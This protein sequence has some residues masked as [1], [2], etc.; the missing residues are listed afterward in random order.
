MPSTQGSACGVGAGIGV[1]VD[2][3]LGAGSEVGTG[4]D[5]ALS[6]GFGADS[7]DAVVMA[8]IL[9]FNTLATRG[10]VV[11]GLTTG[12]SAA[13]EEADEINS[14]SSAFLYFVIL[15]IPKDFARVRNSSNDN[16]DRFI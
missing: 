7:S 2:F 11:R 5:F 8:V 10:F 1:G 4:A 9:G 14:I 12:T 13:T 15:L 16:S 6:G 3:A